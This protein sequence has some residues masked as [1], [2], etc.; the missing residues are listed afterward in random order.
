MVGD[1][2]LVGIAAEVGQN[3]PRARKGAFGKNDPFVPARVVARFAVSAMIA[4]IQMS[5]KLCGAA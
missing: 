4:T 2:D 1:S 5:A 3:L